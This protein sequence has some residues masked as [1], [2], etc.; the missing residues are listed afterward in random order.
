MHTTSNR[1]LVIGNDKN[2]WKD[3]ITLKSGVELFLAPSAK[4][5]TYDVKYS[6][7]VVGT[8]GT[9]SGYRKNDSEVRTKNGYLVYFNYKTMLKAPV[10]RLPLNE[11]IETEETNIVPVWECDY[12]DI[13]CFVENGIHPIGDWVLLE[14]IED[15]ETLGNGTLINPYATVKQSYAK[16]YAISPGVTLDTEDGPMKEGDTVIFDH[17]QGAFENEIE[18]MKLWCCPADV[19]F[20]VV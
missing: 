14:K 5:E 6:G 16:V 2:R 4:S 1:V 20:C 19:I 11:I 7:I 3:R 8:P 13:F 10:T 12:S 9:L 17:S 15:V 18:G